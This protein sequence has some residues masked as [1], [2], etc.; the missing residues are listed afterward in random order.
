MKYITTRYKLPR[1]TLP[2][3]RIGERD[4]YGDKDHDS[5]YEP[6]IK[7]ICDRIDHHPDSWKPYI[8]G[9]ESMV[10][11]VEMEYGE[12]MDY[13]QRGDLNGVERELVDIAA[14]CMVA[15]KR[16]KRMD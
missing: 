5:G 15:L 1:L 14:A 7:R 9:G 6:I 3:I 10:G 13:R 2:T 8:L 4:H 12:M 16:M 11:A